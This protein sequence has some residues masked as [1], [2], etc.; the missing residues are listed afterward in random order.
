MKLRKALPLTLL[1][2]FACTGFAQNTG[3]VYSPDVTAD[4][5]AVEVRFAYD[6]D[7]ESLAT[8]VHYQYAFND[9]F[10]L[11]GIAA[12]NNNRDEDFDYRYFR[13]EGQY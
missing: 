13:L 12:V 6:E 2:A 8:R 5:Q 1:V 10:R 11:R 3:T 7:A 9:A 4:T